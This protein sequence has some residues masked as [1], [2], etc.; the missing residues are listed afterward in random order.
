[1]LQIS[2]EALREGCERAHDLFMLNR[3]RGWEDAA[4]GFDA[5]FDAFGVDAGM[6]ERLHDALVELV[7]LK[8]DPM[9]EAT[10]A[11]SMLAG[12]VVGLFVADS[13]IPAD[14]PELPIVPS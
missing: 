5:V 3:L 10:I 1:M 2:A 6:R 12:L 11:V 7:P 14:E 4:E 8:G 13:A 9:V